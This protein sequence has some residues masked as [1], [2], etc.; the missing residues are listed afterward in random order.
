M[1]TPITSLAKSSAFLLLLALAACAPSPEEKVKREEGRQEALLESS[2]YAACMR[3]VQADEEKV[4]ACVAA[5]LA[6]EG[7]TDGLDCVME[8]DEGPCRGTPRYNA[9]IHA[10][11]DCKG[12]IQRETQLSEGDCMQLLLNAQ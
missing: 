8:P 6:A 7:Y 3:A 10:G 12:S 1:K 5:R 9:Q 11:N 2:G 4:S